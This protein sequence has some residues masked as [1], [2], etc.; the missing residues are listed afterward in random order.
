L[1]SFGKI[2]KAV[3]KFRTLFPQRDLCIK[4]QNIDLA[5]F[6]AIFSPTRPV[7]LPETLSRQFFGKRVKPAS[8]DFFR[9]QLERR[10]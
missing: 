6:R 3:Q 8:L 1:G 5:T 4:Y 9:G 7:T 10:L 2:I